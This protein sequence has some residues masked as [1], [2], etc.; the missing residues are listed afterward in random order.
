MTRKDFM[1]SAGSQQISFGNDLGLERR[2]ILRKAE[3]CVLAKEQERDFIN[4][5]LGQLT[6]EREDLDGIISWLSGVRGH[7]RRLSTFKTWV[8]W[9]LRGNPDL[10]F[11]DKKYTL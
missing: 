8:R 11:I 10:G 4:T 6:G 3:M 5:R 7:W 2:D 9:H 1:N